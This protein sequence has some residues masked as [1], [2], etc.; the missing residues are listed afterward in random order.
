M[1]DFDF[2]VDV[3]LVLAVDVSRSMDA[4]EQ[5]IQREGY[6]AAFRHPDVIEAIQSGPLGRIAVT[7]FEWAG[8][9]DRSVLVPWMVVANAADGDALAA[10]LDGAAQVR[11]SGTSISGAILQAGGLFGQAFKGYR[12]TVDISG[13]GPN[14]AGRAVEEARDWLLQRGATINGLPIMLNRTYGYGPYGVPDLDIYYQDCVIGG[15]GAFTIA[16]RS[17]DEFAQ[18]IRRK[19]I[20]EIAGLPPRL[21]FAAEV[22][23]QPRVDCL[24]GEKMRRGLSDY[25]RF[26]R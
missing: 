13:D 6:I 5:R 2:D 24:I 25:D 7:Y 3:E 9:G 20:L 19:L 15:P 8:V 16:V 21:M 17:P 18:A 4:E 12:R 26:R 14:N 1:D 10:M 22:E 11:V 23:A